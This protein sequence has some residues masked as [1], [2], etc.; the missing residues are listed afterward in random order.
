[1]CWIRNTA[2]LNLPKNAVGKD[3]LKTSYKDR[4]THLLKH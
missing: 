2:L 4:Q 1:M 3:A